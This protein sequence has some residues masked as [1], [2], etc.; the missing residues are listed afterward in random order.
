MA[1]KMNTWQATGIEEKFLTIEEQNLLKKLR[2][3]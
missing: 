2:E 1:K 3:K